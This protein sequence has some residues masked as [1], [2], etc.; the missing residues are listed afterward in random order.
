MDAKDEGQ[1]E[2]AKSLG[3]L[4][5]LARARNL[6]KRALSEIGKKGAAGRAKAAARAKRERRKSRS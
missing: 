6:S 3:R 4:G 5:G 2:A 1:H